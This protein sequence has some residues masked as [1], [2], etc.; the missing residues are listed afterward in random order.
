M[1]APLHSFSSKVNGREE[2]IKTIQ[3]I[4]LYIGDIDP[5]SHVYLA[6]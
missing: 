3:E 2:P 6:L 1:N 5:S 4:D